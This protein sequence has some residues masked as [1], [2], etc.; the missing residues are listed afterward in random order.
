[1]L[2]AKRLT[3]LATRLPRLARQ[4]ALVHH[5]NKTFSAALQAFIRH[6]EGFVN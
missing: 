5:R 1:L 2:G 4:F 6:C 3:V